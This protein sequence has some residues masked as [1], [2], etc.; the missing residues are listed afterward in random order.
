M[1]IIAGRYCSWLVGVLM[2]IT[3][4]VIRQPAFALWRCGGCCGVFGGLRK[5]T[6]PRLFKLS[7]LISFRRLVSYSDCSGLACEHPLQGFGKPILVYLPTAIKLLVR[8]LFHSEKR[9]YKTRRRQFLLC[10]EGFPN[11]RQQ[12]RQDSKLV[13]SNVSGSLGSLEGARRPIAASQFSDGEEGSP[14]VSKAVIVL[15]PLTGSSC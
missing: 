9:I 12:V 6:L 7:S 11:V 1:I 3:C 14:V 8:C 5:V 10:P 15:P 2:P 4:N 13:C